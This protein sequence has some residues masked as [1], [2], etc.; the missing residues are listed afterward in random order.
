MGRILRW[1]SVFSILIVLCAAGGAFWGYS[2]YVKPG[3]LQSDL[4]VVIPKGAGKI[5]IA[6]LL[7]TRGVITQPLVFRAAVRTIAREKSLRAG[8]FLFPKSASTKA[9]VGILQTGKTVVRR[10]TVAEGL[11]VAE[12]MDRLYQT[13][14]LEGDI[15]T[16]VSEGTLLPETY[17]FSY[18]DSRDAMVLRMRT[19]MDKA[20]EELWN[21]R[22]RNL[23][24][25]TAADT[26]VMAS[27][28]EKETA[29]ADERARVAG[30][31]VNRLRRG[32]RLQSDPTVVYGVTDGTGALG[33]P[34][35]RSDL[36]NPHPYNTYIHK[37][38]PPTPIANPG[39]S[40]IEAALN[41]AATDDLYFVAD[42]EGGHAFART[43]TEHNRNVARWRRLTKKQREA[44]KPR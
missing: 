37:G 23:P 10:I 6:N 41:P 3:P 12:V 1:L 20:F 39:R 44:E 27:I 30:V 40:S 21:R 7:Q 16:R 33:R 13:E 17:H 32:M 5:E 36:N 25:E 24:Y 14:G 38:L 2:E 42:G 8:E 19:A 11:T 34:I 29:R 31:F 28:I 35:Q 26:L 18:G 9:V 4:A 43:L 22:A 15:T